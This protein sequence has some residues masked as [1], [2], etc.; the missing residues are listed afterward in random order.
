MGDSVW[1]INPFAKAYDSNL[2]IG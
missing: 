2:G 1:Y